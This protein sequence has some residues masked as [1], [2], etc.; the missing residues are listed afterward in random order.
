MSNKSKLVLLIHVFFGQYSLQNTI[1][2][3]D[4]IKAFLISI[5]ADHIIRLIKYIFVIKFKIMGLG[6]MKHAPWNDNSAS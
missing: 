1:M 4:L 5:S 6:R 3:N 2:F